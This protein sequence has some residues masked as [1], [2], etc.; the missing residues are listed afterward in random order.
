MKEERKEL[1]FVYSDFT[2]VSVAD[3]CRALALSLSRWCSTWC[4]WATVAAAYSQLQTV[5]R[6]HMV[7]GLAARGSN[8]FSLTT[9]NAANFSD[10]RGAART[11]CQSRFP[12]SIC[13]T[14]TT[15]DKWINGAADSA[16]Q[17]GTENGS[18]CRWNWRDAGTQ[19]H[20]KT[21]MHKL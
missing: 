12:F 5:C 19:C 20:K 13:T 3:R 11:E 10:R 14:T 15:H 1:V 4:W 2:F 7:R 16:L 21:A 9:Y 8:I 17:Q 18:N 6:P